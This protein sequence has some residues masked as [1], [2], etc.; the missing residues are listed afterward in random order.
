MQPNGSLP[1]GAGLPPRQP[2][3]SSGLFTAAALFAVVCGLLLLLTG[4]FSSRPAGETPEA[5]R[6]K[7]MVEASKAAAASAS[8]AKGALEGANY[9]AAKRIIEEQ[10]KE[11]TRLQV[12]LEA[13]APT[14]SAR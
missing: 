8:K 4:G 14:P 9:G 6:H 5:A 1:P 12:E 10:Q 11:L 13:A 2:A 3:G 7:R